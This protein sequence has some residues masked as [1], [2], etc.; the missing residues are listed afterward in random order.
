MVVLL[1]VSS[2]FHNHHQKMQICDSVL[3]DLQ[4]A[5]EV[6]V[7]LQVNLQN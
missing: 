6:H 3:A 1:S 2:Y 4:I 5:D 7:N